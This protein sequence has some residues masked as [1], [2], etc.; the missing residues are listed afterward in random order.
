M[1]AFD[2][3]ISYKEEREHLEEVIAS[4]NVPGYEDPALKAARESSD[5][6]PVQCWTLRGCSGLMGLEVALELECPHSRADCYNPCPAECSYTACS[7]PW[8]RMTSDINLIFDET[9]DRQAAIKKTCY[10]CAYFLKHGP[11]I[12]ERVSDGVS[13]PDTATK[14]S[15]SRVTIHLF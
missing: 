12:H 4:L 2:L 15:D 13:A 8:H 11:R 5:A 10:T 3:S 7:R 1:G 14:D 9:V 6:S